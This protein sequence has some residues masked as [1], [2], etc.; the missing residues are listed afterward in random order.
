MPYYCGKG[1][2]A[3]ILKFTN[4]SRAG[5]VRKG[6]VQVD[7]LKWVK[8]IDLDKPKTA[9]IGRCTWVFHPPEVGFRW[10]LLILWFNCYVSIEY[11]L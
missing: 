8:C 2:V 7:L 5:R 4:K 3:P 11:R 1:W 10:C 6:I 9:K